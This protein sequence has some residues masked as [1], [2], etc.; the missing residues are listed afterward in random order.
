MNFGSHIDDMNCDIVS[1]SLDYTTV[2]SSEGDESSYIYDMVIH[3][4]TDI[5]D[6]GQD[7]KF[8]MQV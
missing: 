3:G 6:W 8:M 1:L 7:R 5:A 2:N 4:H